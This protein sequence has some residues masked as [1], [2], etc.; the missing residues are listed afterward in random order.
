MTGMFDNAPITIK[1]P[2][3]AEQTVKPLVWLKT[4]KSLTCT[5]GNVLNLNSDELIKGAVETAQLVKDRV[6]RMARRK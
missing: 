1:C 4:N 5:C 3:C 2:K 6:R